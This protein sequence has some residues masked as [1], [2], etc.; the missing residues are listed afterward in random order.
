MKKNNLLLKAFQLVCV[1]LLLFSCNLNKNKTDAPDGDSLSNTDDDDNSSGVD[2]SNDDDD[3]NDAVDD[4]DNDN[5]NND[6]ADDDDDVDDDDDNN[7]DDDDDNYP[8][9]LITAI[10]TN[11]GE[12]AAYV[13]HLYKGY[14]D[15]LGFSVLNPD[16]GAVHTEHDCLP[17]CDGDCVEYMCEPPPIEV[18]QILPGGEVRFEWDGFGYE[19]ETCISKEEREVTCYTEVKLPDGQYYLQFCYSTMLQVNDDYLPRRWSNDILSDSEPLEPVC[20]KLPIMLENGHHKLEETFNATLAN[21]EKPWEYCGNAWIFSPH[22]ITSILNGVNSTVEDSS[23]LMPVIGKEELINAGCWRLGGMAYYISGD[24]GIG[25]QNGFFYSTR[26]CD[27]DIQNS[28]YYY[29]LPPLKA[30]SYEVWIDPLTDRIADSWYFSVKECTGCPECPTEPTKNIG[31]ECSRDCFCKQGAV[32]NAWGVC[33]KHCLTNLDCPENYG[34]FDNQMTAQPVK[35]CHKLEEDE[36]RS[37]YDCKAGFY[38]KKV[39]EDSGFRRCMPDMD[40][41]LLENGMGIHCAC[42]AECPG[43]QSCVKMEFNF[44]KGFCAIRCRDARECPD[45]WKCLEMTQSGL[46]AICTP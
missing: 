24:Y 6:S 36:C 29:V 38:C 10:L 40:T 19:Y 43:V 45:G 8:D 46:Q 4:D 41:R 23:V 32:C 34:C 44:V 12:E 20:L 11:T 33:E 14:F 1:C 15:H 30:G 28:Y 39:N 2:Y 31:G 26:V 25:L 35:L 22:P 18:M 21:A 9:R 13:R 42:D 3:D 27:K 16:G 17:M 37:D 5:N 7:D